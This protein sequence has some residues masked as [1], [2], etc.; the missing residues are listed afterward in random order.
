[1]DPELIVICLQP[2]HQMKYLFVLCYTGWYVLEM[3]SNRTSKCP[4]TSWPCLIIKVNSLLNIINLWLIQD[5][6]PSWESPIVGSAKHLGVRIRK[7]GWSF[8]SVE[9][10][11]NIETY[12]FF[13]Q[14]WF[15]ICLKPQL[16]HFLFARIHW[17]YLVG[18]W[19]IWII[20]PF[21]W[22]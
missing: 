22:E 3:G 1:M 14:C 5:S 8:P 6:P 15:K 19:N 7:M 18:V 4:M 20:C 21:S 13:L 16:I 2:R 17:T 11:R 12:S 10:L 9:L